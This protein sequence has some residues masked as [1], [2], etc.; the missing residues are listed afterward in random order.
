V[1]LRHACTVLVHV[2]TVLLAPYFR[3]AGRCD[4]GFPGPCPAPYIMACLWVLVTTLLL[5]VQ[6]SNEHPLDMTVRASLNDAANH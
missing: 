3:H 5:N 1:T 4:A 2:L 6:A